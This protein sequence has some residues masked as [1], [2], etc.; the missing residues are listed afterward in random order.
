MRT[1]KNFEFPGFLL[2]GFGVF[3]F[4][5]KLKIWTE[6]FKLN[7]FF[8][9]LQAKFFLY[10]EWINGYLNGITCKYRCGPL[11]YVG[12][13]QLLNLNFRR[14]WSDFGFFISGI[15][16][17]CSSYRNN[18]KQKICIPGSDKGMRK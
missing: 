12:A 18:P 4:S 15:F 11:N 2:R 1:H 9:R 7:L 13:H 10:L 17:S 5:K 3:E 8:W 6:N 16:S 14:F